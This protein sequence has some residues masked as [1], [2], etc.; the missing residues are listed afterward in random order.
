MS[1]ITGDVMVSSLLTVMILL[2]ILSVPAIYITVRNSAKVIN[3][4]LLLKAVDESSES[5]QKHVAD[6]WNVVK[7]PAVYITMFTEQLEKLNS[8]KSLSTQCIL[9]VIISIILWFTAGYDD[10]MKVIVIA[11]DIISILTVFYGRIYKNV[12]MHEYLE[13]LNETEKEN[14]TGTIDTMY[15]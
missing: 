15:G 11:A 3:R 12:Y 9:A 1:V 4:Y 14:G 5:S 7:T 2:I 10:T 13:M 6:E 8:L